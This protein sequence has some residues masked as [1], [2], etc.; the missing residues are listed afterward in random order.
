MFFSF[1]WQFKIYKLGRYRIVAAWFWSIEGR[2]NGH[3]LLATEDSGKS[4]P[5]SLMIL[6]WA[7]GYQFVNFHS[8][9][10]IRIRARSILNRIKMN[11]DH[12]YI[13]SS[14]SGLSNIRS[15]VLAIIT[16]C[17][18]S[19]LQWANIRKFNMFSVYKPHM[20]DKCGFCTSCFNCHFTFPSRICTFKG[21]ARK[22]EFLF[23]PRPVPGLQ[24]GGK[25]VQGLTF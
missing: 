2:E 24:Q 10:E 23:T 16:C 7:C 18:L 12:I 22:R 5:A 9:R 15:R 3:S 1:T 20:L 17:W 11:L 21:F 8:S 19:G 4:E 25:S 14:R 13:T 6:T